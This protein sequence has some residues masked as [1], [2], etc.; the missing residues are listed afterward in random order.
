MF[1]QMF[2]L[3]IFLWKIYCT[4]KLTSIN[5]QISK[6]LNQNRFIVI[7]ISQNY[8]C[9]LILFHHVRVWP[10]TWSTNYVGTCKP[11]PRCFSWDRPDKG[12]ESRTVK[13]HRP[14][15]TSRV[16]PHH[17]LPDQDE[18]P[19]KKETFTLNTCPF[20]PSPIEKLV[21][22]FVAMGSLLF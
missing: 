3:I 19:Q 18:K 9:Y 22:E 15:E 4:K 8:L 17:R 20:T 2:Y 1:V 11:V 5:Q 12:H 16:N 6:Y 13:N 21:S 10:M 14:L 7:D